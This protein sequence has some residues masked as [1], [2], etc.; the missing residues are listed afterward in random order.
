MIYLSVKTAH[1]VAIILFIGGL[2]LQSALLRSLAG[3]PA[4][5]LPDERRLMLQ[6]QQWDRFVTTPALLL[7]WLLGATMAVKGGW[8]GSTWLSIKLVMAAVLSALHG[9]NAG[10]I[11]RMIGDNARTL[12]VRHCFHSWAPAVFTAVIVCLAVLKPF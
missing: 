2:L 4:P 11:R 3:A 12:S 6:V 10:T 5:R 1:L 8:F 9:V 7:V